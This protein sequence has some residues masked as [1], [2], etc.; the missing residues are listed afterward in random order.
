VSTVIT[1]IDHGSPAEKAGIAAGEKL[2]S[3]N[4][5]PIVDVLDYK[6]YC[7]D[8]KLELELETSDGGK[9]MLHIAKREGQEL[10]LNFETYLMDKARR[11][12]NNCIFCFIDQNPK[13]MRESIYFKDDDSR[14]SFLLGNYI[15]MTN[16]SEREIQRIIDLRIS[17]VNVSIHTTDPELRCKMLGNRFAGRGFELMQKFAEAGIRMNAQIVVC[18]G[19][20]DGIALLNS[21]HDLATLHPMVEGCSIVPFGMTDHREGL[22]EIEPFDA[23]SARNTVELVDDFGTKCKNYYGD[24]IFYCSDEFYIKAGMPL[25]DEEYYEGYNHLENGVGMLRLLKEEFVAAL[26]FEEPEGSPL[27]AAIVTGQ[28]AAPYL[29]ELVDL[30]NE[31]WHNISAEVYAIENDFFGHSI[32]VAGLVTGGDIVRQLN[33]K[34]LPKRMLIPENMLRSGE[35]VFLYDMH[36]SDVEAQL[37]VEITVVPCDG[38]ALLDEIIKTNQ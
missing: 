4:G 8:P 16:L 17:P 3:V 22:T 2:I 10:G 12:S 11:C 21:M 26:K 34:K 9:R 13:G 5:K 28:A 36:V 35:D 33:G 1:S 19:W 18:P 24:R 37:N 25:P 14:L 6:F 30:A 32:T 20:N 7:Y 23:V 15:T 31:K 38:G 29:Q 27:P